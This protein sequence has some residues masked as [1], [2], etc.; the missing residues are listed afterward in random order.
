MP[1]AMVRS[2]P[3]SAALCRTGLARLPVR[4]WALARGRYVLLWFAMSL[5]MIL[6]RVALLPVVPIPAPQIHDEFSY[7]L[8]ADT[9][10][11]GRAADPT[12]SHPEFFASPHIL[13]KPSFTSK[14]PP[15]QALVLALGQRVFGDPYWGV[16]L[17][18]GSMI[19]LFC[20][21]AAAWLPPQWAIIGGVFC[22]VRFFTDYWFNS[23][24]GGS[25]AACGG[26]LIVGGLGHFLRGRLAGARFSIATGAV[27][28]FA[29]RPYEGFVLC[30]T[31]LLILAFR[32]LRLPVEQK[33]GV[34]KTVVPPSLAILL[35]A[36]IAN[37]W[38]NWRV[39]GSPT[40]LPYVE[41]IHQNA[42]VP[43][44][45]ILPASQHMQSGAESVRRAQQIDEIRYWTFRNKPLPI[46]VGYQ[47]YAVVR[48]TIWHQFLWAALL[49]TA[50][51]WI[52][53]RSG[54]RWLVLLLGTGIVAVLPE[55]WAFSHYT[56]PLTATG[57]ILTL[58]CGRYVWYRAAG[59][60][61]RT[62]LGTGALC[63]AIAVFVAEAWRETK[64]FRPLERLKTI[65][66]LSKMGGKHL[67]FVR[68]LPGWDFGDEW[69]YNTENLAATTVVFAHDLGQ[70]K[71]RELTAYGDRK[72]WLLRLGPKPSDVAFEPFDPR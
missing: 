70:A 54:K 31:A 50:L 23:Y 42:T 18:V 48:S 38:Y 14:Y 53:V 36:A 43:F 15:G 44:L 52:R 66:A 51:P 26:A 1:E 21:A 47:I 11:H 8:A 10:A 9:F 25:V 4:L 13:L 60:R 28:L 24:W 57:L 29:T 69:V 63:L 16:V 27:I 40:R 45:W 17:G 33:H 68:Y 71:D 32:F 34:I 5:V 37:G 7:L 58:A 35:L 59:S 2:I 56:A 67:V 62:L 72:I 30:L 41:W 46:A 61:H 22:C 12:P 19:V 20:W 65:Q 49:L 55:I 64:E 3:Q 6:A 39:T